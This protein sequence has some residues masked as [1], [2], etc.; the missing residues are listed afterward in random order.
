[1]T[2]IRVNPESVQRYG[3][4]AQSIFD[5]MHASLRGLV[6]DV[7]AVRYFGPNAVAFATESGRLAADF[8]NRLHLDMSAMG[9]AVRASTSNIAAALGGQPIA[10]RIDGRP[11]SPP[12]PPV[13][14]FVDVDTTALESLI[15]IVAGRFE[16]LRGALTS[17]LGRLQA[18]DWEG[19]AKLAA[20][21]AVAGFTASSRA[22]C[23][24]AELAITG[25]VRQQL[26]AVVAADR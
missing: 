17:H 3:F 12:A 16:S 6:D 20:V 1:M 23:D 24:A 2:L 9:D 18:T 15:P 13:V 21:D 14:A 26:Q 5:E 25:Y 7:V 8:A 10:L 19:N 4:E 22:S 11:I